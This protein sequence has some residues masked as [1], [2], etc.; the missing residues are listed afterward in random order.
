[1]YK[2]YQKTGTQLMRPYI[3]GEDTTGW[4]ISES[5]TLEVGGMVATDR[6]KV[7]SMWYVSKKF[8]EENYTPCTYNNMVRQDP[9]TGRREMYTESYWSDIEN[10][11]N[12][13]SGLKT[14]DNTCFDDVQKKV[15][16]IKSVGYGDLFELLSKASSVKEG[17]MKSTKAMEIDKVGCVIQVTTQQ[18]NP[19]GSY[20]VAEALSFVPGVC[21]RDFGKDG[22]I[23]TKI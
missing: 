3:E 5:D 13:N 11:N 8:F 10:P 12:H 6:N 7:G 2:E 19:D 18:R 1:M 9:D 4:S 16:D 15:S 14:L 17:W 23:L 22:K 20:A 21:I